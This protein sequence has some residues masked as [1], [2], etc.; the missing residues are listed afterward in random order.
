[1]I[2]YTEA[3]NNLYSTKEDLLIIGLTGRTGS[4]C[5]T[6]AKILHSKLEEL[7]FEYEE[8]DEYTI[9]DKHKFNIV[10]DYIKGER[11]QAFEVIEGSSVILSY[12]FEEGN[13]PDEALENLVN[14]LAQLQEKKSERYLE[15]NDA[16]QLIKD[17]KNLDYMFK[18]VSKNPLSALESILKS[19]NNED[20]IKNY[21]KLY[22]EDMPRYKGILKKVLDKYTCREVEKAKMQDKDAVNYHLYT[23]LF[24]IFGNNI[25]ASGNPYENK[26]N[27]EK[28][29]DFAKRL[30]WLIELIIK[31]NK[32]EEKIKVRNRICIDAIR[33]ANESNYLKDKYRSYY[34]LSISVDEVSRRKR[35]T[36]LNAL[37]VKGIDDVEYSSSYKADAFFCQQNIAQCFEMADIHIYNEQTDSPKKFFLTWQLIKY[38][39]LMIHPGLIT[40]SSLERCM[41]LAYNAKYNS[42]CISRQVGA[43]ITGSDFS[44]K[45]IG[46]NDVPKGQLPCNLR[47]VELYCQGNHEECFS[48]YEIED[49]QFQKALEDINTNVNCAKDDLNGRKYAFCFKDIY[50]GYT[51]EKNQVFTRALHA[52][53]NAFLQISK[54]GGVGI[55]DGFLFVTASPCELCSKKSYQ[56]GIRG[57]YYIDPYPGIAEKHILKFGKKGEGPKMNLFYG[58]IGEAYIALYKPLLAYK[59]ELELVSGIN[60]KQIAKDGKQNNIDEPKTKDLSYDSVEFSIEFKTREDIESIRSVKFRV[61]SGEINQLERKLTWT[62]SSYEG[63][64]ILG[65]P[66]GKFLVKDYG[67]KVSPYRYSINFTDTIKSGD[68]VEYAVRTC[69]KDGAH[70]MHPY[71]AYHIKHPTEKLVLKIILPKDEK[72]MD[73]VVYKRYADEDM[74]IE[75][76]DKNE[77]NKVEWDEKTRTYTLEI[78]EPNLFYMYSLEW[79][80]VEKKAGGDSEIVV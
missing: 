70:S 60:C 6:A 59:D 68:N 35:L 64:T 50:N 17:L 44:I 58:A 28:I 18:K 37:E 27:P 31:K 48:R 67:D 80:F 53:E 23:Y 41:Q 62:G 11:W 8:R 42:G 76:E 66:N 54:Y 2:K 40:P 69:V 57:I 30:S 52:E 10:R 38:V 43:V 3:I 47:D 22:I 7:D 39:T 14:Y 79:E 55:K 36:N 75:Y 74:N 21:Y 19:D 63:T 77:K 61:D 49:I 56:L 29:L 73:A 45:A 9:W 25:R 71:F 1:M 72:I 20:K 15:I 5:S 32:L 33:N 26:L 16:D 24:Q 51:G 13:N 78:N 12:V 46:W 65:E 4:G 34:L